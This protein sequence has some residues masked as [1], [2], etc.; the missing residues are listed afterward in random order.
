[1]LNL[2]GGYRVG[3]ITV[4]D[5]SWV[6]DQTLSQTRLQQEGIIVLGI[7]R[8]DGSYLGA[9]QGDTRVCPGDQLI[10]YGLDSDLS[11]LHDRLAGSAGDARHRQAVQDQAQR[12][13]EQTDQDHYSRQSNR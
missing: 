8:D 12:V 1:M 2:T 4:R 9:P 11:E 10:V 13:N 6:A 5:D 7:T 3:E